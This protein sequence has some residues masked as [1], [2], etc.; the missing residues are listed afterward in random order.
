MC[1]VVYHAHEVYHVVIMLNI[2]PADPSHNQL[3]YRGR[4]PNKAF[5]LFLRYEV[6]MTAGGSDNLVFK[7]CLPPTPKTFLQQTHHLSHHFE[8]WNSVRLLT[9]LEVGPD[10]SKSEQLPVLLH[11]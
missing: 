7:P 5:P 3:N 9:K 4:N 11:G 2:L 8:S 1:V 6:N 10:E